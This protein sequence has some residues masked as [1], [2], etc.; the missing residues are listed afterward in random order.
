M[1]TSAWHSGRDGTGQASVSGLGALNVTFLTAH[2]ASSALQGQSGVPE[3]LG[4][5]ADPLEAQLSGQGPAGGQAWVWA[6]AG[7][8]ARE[9]WL[10]GQA[11]GG[12]PW[13]E[14][15]GSADPTDTSKGQQQSTTRAPRLPEPA[16]CK[17]RTF[18]S[19]SDGRQ[20]TSSLQLNVPGPEMDPCPLSRLHPCAT[21][22]QKQQ[23]LVFRA[24]CACVGGGS[25][26]WLW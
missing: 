18:G 4:P 7:P 19:L 15:L 22:A 10:P 2:T 25:Q 26:F 11:V 9:G 24:V 14:L 17:A 13:Q 16:C 3:S 21:K 12:E 23:K 8:Q 5:G 6:G 20:K 1:E